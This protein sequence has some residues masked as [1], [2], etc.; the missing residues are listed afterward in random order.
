MSLS[1]INGTVTA[2]VSSGNYIPSGVRIVNEGTAS[3]YLQFYATTGATASV[4]ATFG[5]K[6]LGNTVETFN[7][8]GCPVITAQC[9]STFTVTLTATPGEGL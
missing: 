2:V 9:G 8:R 1:V 5:M 4:S 6:M 3:V 7:L